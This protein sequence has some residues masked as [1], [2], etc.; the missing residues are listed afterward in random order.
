MM[1]TKGRRTAGRTADVAG[2]LRTVI[3]RLAFHL[4]KAATRQGVT[5]TR[6]TVLVTLS[7]LGPQRPGD[8]GAMLGISAASM[9]RV[10]EALECGGLVTR[11]KDPDDQRASRLELTRSGTAILT[12]VHH[13]GTS[14]LARGIDAL[15]D[16]ERAALTAA[17]PVLVKLADRHLA[18]DDADGR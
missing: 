4:R 15:E 13:E 11:S 14:E 17:L 1:A 3:N 10:V 8:L 18:T 6:M 16:E 7:K 2:E 9:S 12:D 5:P